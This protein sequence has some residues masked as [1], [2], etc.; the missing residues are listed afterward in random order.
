M[1]ANFELGFHTLWE[2]PTEDWVGIGFGL[3]GLLLVSLFY[4]PRHLNPKPLSTIQRLAVLAPWAALLAF[5]VKSGMVTG[6]R[7]IA[8]YYPLLLS[9]LLLR[10]QIQLTKSLWWRSVLCLALL[11]AFPVVIVTPG[12]PLWPAQS[13]L[14]EL[15]KVKPGNRLITRARQVYTVYSARSDSLAAVR[16]LL[17]PG[18]KVVGF[19]ADGDDM[20]VSLWRPYGQRRVEH[21]LLTD[22]PAQIRE[23]KIEYVVVGGAHL[24]ANETNLSD[25][26]DRTGAE[27]VASTTA[28]VKVVEGSQP[29]Y[30]VRLKPD[31][32]K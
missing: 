8:P 28:T 25:W 31:P 22:S 24:K 7:I 6:A 3:S 17:P 10:N 27:L 11:L 30:V 20:D 19:M 16:A 29:W 23:R 14:A 15:D 21:I 12:H 4:R 2:I 9:L 26:L 1:V 13:V 32:R 18:L 5:C